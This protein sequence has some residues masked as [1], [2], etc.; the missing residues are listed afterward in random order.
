MVL[1]MKNKL[2]KLD[3]LLE[4][5]YRIRN[6]RASPFEWK[7]YDSLK[8]EI[9]EIEQQNKALTEQVKNITTDRD[10][11]LREKHDALKG[12]DN[13]KEQVKQLQ[14]EKELLAKSLKIEFTGHNE[15]VNKFFD[16]KS[17]R[18][19]LK[20]KIEKIRVCPF[21]TR[22][23]DCGM[24]GVPMGREDK[25]CGNCNSFR[26][27]IVIRETTIKEILGEEETKKLPSTTGSHKWG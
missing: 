19:Q 23:F 27:E 6:K 8:K 14:E 11:I 10:I 25:Q 24:S 9:Q 12:I 22:C 1:V 5:E 20:S 13:L 3:R 15:I 2:N 17:E 26:T 7:E 16:I 4:L 21:M 18:D